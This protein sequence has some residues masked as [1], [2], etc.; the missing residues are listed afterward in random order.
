VALTVK[1]VPEQN[2]Y[3]A[4]LDGELA[5]YLEYRKNGDTWSLTHAFTLP[6]QRGKGVAAEV[7]RFALD[8]AHDAGAIVRP[9]CPF[10]ADYVAANPQY[11]AL[12]R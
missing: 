11:A 10:V 6:H 5:G 7:T 8:A 1:D 12:T 9:I 4:R 2:R 3:E